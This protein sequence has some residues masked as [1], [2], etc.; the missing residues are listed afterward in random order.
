MITSN[1][2]TA[3]DSPYLKMTGIPGVGGRN[4]K[5]ITQLAGQARVVC[6]HLKGVGIGLMAFALW[7]GAL[8][9]GN[10]YVPNFSFESPVVPP[11]TPFAGP[12]IDDW[13]K[14]AQPFWYDPAQNFDTPWDFL[15]GGIEI[16]HAVCRINPSFRLRER[17]HHGTGRGISAPATNR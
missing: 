6:K 7:G 3:T 1:T 17:M 16:G 2:I 13:A 5:F 4:S 12:A 8:Q 11:V 15:M 10:I 9:A 14:S